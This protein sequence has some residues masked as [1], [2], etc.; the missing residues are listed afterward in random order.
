MTGRSRLAVADFFDCIS[1]VL[2]A[3]SNGAFGRLRPVFD[4][5]ACGFCT[6]LNRLPRFGRGLLYGL[7]GLFDWT[8]VLSAQ[9]QRNAN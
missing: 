3:F 5:F 8:L 1:R 6:M 7:A 2:Q 9:N 4:G